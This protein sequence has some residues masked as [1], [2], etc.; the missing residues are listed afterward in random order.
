M[1]CF[2]IVITLATRIQFS[3]LDVV[4][5]DEGGGAG[6]GGVS[7]FLGGKMFNRSQVHNQLLSSVHRWRHRPA[8]IQRQGFKIVSILILSIYHLVD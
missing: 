1:V 4:Y 5:I 3:N 7:I 2:H 6:E 8:K